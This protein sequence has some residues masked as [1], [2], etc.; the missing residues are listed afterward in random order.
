MRQKDQGKVFVASRAR[1]DLPQVTMTM[2]DM[3]GQPEGSDR[4]AASPRGQRAGTPKRRVFTTAYKRR[5]LER[6]DALTD[7]A[8]RGALLRREGLYHSHLEYWRKNHSEGDTGAA[9]GTPAGRPARSAAEIENE[10]L[11]AEN[12]RLAAEL[13]RTKAALDVAGK[14]YAL[15]ETLS[16]SADSD[17]RPTR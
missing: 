3:P 16:E 9:T 5:I 1:W 10:R 11:R 12:E 4:S 14:V 2:A 13:T 8:E 6:Y 15:L 17:A 7:P